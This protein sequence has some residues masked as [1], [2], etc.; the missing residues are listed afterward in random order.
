MNKNNVAEIVGE[1]KMTATMGGCQMANANALDLTTCEVW[2]DWY[3][4]ELLVPVGASTAL[5]CLAILA[6]TRPLPSYSKLQ[7]YNTGLPGIVPGMYA[8]V[9]DK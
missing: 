8:G 5:R 9:G 4:T 1:R 7:T 6:S 3:S 2:Q